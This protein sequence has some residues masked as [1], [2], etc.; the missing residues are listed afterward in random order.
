[1]DYVINLL[2]SPVSAPT[3]LWAIILNWIEGGI[4]NYGWVIILFTLLIKVCMSPLD[5]L[6]KFSTKKSSLVQ[7]KLAPQIARINKKY[8]K[9]RT[10]NPYYNL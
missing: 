3:G 10:S 9:N 1:M 6:I 7:Q 2:A 4:V 5:L 8:Q